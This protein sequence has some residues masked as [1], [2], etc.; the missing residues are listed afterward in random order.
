MTLKEIT[1]TPF[2]LSSNILEILE[3][4]SKIVVFKKNELI[5]AAGDDNTD[6]YFLKSG[7]ARIY[8]TLSTP[9][10]DVSCWNRICYLGRLEMWQHL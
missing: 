9:P 10:H 2:A 5:I 8:Y 3:E 4:N 6:F 7:L 1:D